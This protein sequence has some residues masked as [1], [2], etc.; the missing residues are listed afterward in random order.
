MEGQIQEREQ[1]VDS[2]QEKELELT[3]DTPQELVVV[4]LAVELL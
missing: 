4:G 2:L 3:V 1:V